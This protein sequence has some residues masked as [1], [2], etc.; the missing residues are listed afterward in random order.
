M[1][2]VKPTQGPFLQSLFCSSY[3]EYIPGADCGSSVAVS[4][5]SRFVEQEE[6]QKEEALVATEGRKPKVRARVL[7]TRP[8]TFRN[9]EQNSIDVKVDGTVDMLSKV[10]MD[11]LSPVQS[12]V[13]QGSCSVEG[14]PMS[15][16]QLSYLR[17]TASW[18]AARSSRASGC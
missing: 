16:L 14:S 3:T 1:K 7:R 12:I 11:P 2:Y 6:A 17:V 15:F 4:H 10:L 9:I 18:C 5:R 13:L 8:R